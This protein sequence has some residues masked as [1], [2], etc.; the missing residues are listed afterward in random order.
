MLKK[1]DASLRQCWTKPDNRTSAW[2]DQLPW[3]RV[4]EQTG[5]E[6]RERERC[7]PLT[8]FYSLWLSL[9]ALWCF[10]DLVG[11]S[12]GANW[13]FVSVGRGHR[14]LFST[15][16]EKKMMFKHKWTNKSKCSSRWSYVTRN[17][18][19]CHSVKT[20]AN[21]ECTLVKFSN[22]HHHFAT[23]NVPET[24]LETGTIFFSINVLRGFE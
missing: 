24:Q 6:A 12:T 1:K 8:S 9:I 20:P 7:N 16:S 5:V 13:L 22:Y 11:V 21:Q 15:S 17:F 23:K 2:P 10:P 4:V 14:R 18:A 19:F 3:T